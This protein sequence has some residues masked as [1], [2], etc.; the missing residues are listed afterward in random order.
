M[1]LQ[2]VVAPIWRAAHHPWFWLRRRSFRQCASAIQSLA[3]RNH[4]K[5]LSLLSCVNYKSSDREKNVKVLCL[6]TSNELVK[7]PRVRYRSDLEWSLWQH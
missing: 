6:V 3:A 5:I 7:W 4:K 1:S 2:I